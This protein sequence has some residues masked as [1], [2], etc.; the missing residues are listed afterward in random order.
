MS[1]D[2]EPRSQAPLG[3]SP[4]VVVAPH[5]DDESLGCAGVIMGAVARGVD[6]RVV[7]LTY[8]DG[9]PAAAALHAGKDEDALAPEDFVALGQERARQ[10][11]VATRA[12]G[13][14][15]THLTFLGY[16]D[17]G[18]AAMLD[19]SDGGPWTQPFTGKSHTYGFASPEHHTHV[20]GSPAPY[21][22]DAVVNDLAEIIAASRAEEI[23]VTHPADGHAD[24]RAAC[25]LVVRAAGAASFDGTL[26]TYLVHSADHRWPLPR[27]VTPD[28]PFDPL[29]DPSGIPWPPDE[30]R[31][32]SP[33][34][35]ARKL[36]A[37]EAYSLETQLSG[38]YVRSFVKSEEVF[39]RG[40]TRSPSR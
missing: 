27:G 36:E 35:A 22:R 20:H 24:H 37:I 14:D 34:E 25:E 8:G 33:P 15:E 19:A 13:L 4:V 31:P 30:R 16:P 40:A 29:P 38:E 10:A 28:A 2:D 39:W 18:L 7:F 21:T 5:P 26:Y 6:V 12:L 11:G 9:F 32:L 23:Y 3:A 1:S 17:S